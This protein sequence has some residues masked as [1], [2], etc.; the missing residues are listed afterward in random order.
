M[1]S[2]HSVLSLSE[3]NWSSQ[4]PTHVKAKPL[5]R[6]NFV[7]LLRVSLPLQKDHHKQQ[8]HEFCLPVVYAQVYYLM[9]AP[10]PQHLIAQDLPMLHC[11]LALQFHHQLM[12]C[13][14]NLHLHFC[15]SVV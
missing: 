8:A 3:Q 2:F 15:S 9:A 5:K 13:P 4:V 6:F 11:V 7:V 1:S 10:S 14:V 12:H